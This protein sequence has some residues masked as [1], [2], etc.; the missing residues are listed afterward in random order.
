[1]ILLTHIV[2][3]EWYG[4]CQ[5]RDSRPK[6]LRE[7]V[8]QEKEKLSMRKT[9]VA[10]LALAGSISTASYAADREIK[11][12]DRLDASADTL[13]DMMRAS[14]KVSPRICSIRRGAS[15]SYPA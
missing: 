6:V 10:I 11:V 4:A 7:P 1:M 5:Y 8:R 12:D 2:E 13:T 14:D 9:L 3:E 15:S